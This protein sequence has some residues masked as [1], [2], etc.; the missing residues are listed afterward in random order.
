MYK[1]LHLI[2]DRHSFVMGFDCV[3][4]HDKKNLQPSHNRLLLVEKV[5]LHD[6]MSQRLLHVAFVVHHQKFM[7]VQACTK[8]WIAPFN[9]GADTKYLMWFPLYSRS[10][11][12]KK[13]WINNLLLLKTQ[14]KGDILMHHWLWLKIFQAI[15]MHK[16]TRYYIFNGTYIHYI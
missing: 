9:W 4:W 15:V 7:Q 12:G 10:W 1:L 16:K 11:G 2:R 8:I 3:I 13:L 14:C 5:S 6:N